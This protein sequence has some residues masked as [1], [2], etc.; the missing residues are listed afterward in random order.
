[1]MNTNCLSGI[2]CPYCGFED[3]FKIEVVALARVTDEGVMSTSSEGS[4]NEWFPDSPIVCGRCRRHGVV[5]EFDGKPTKVHLVQEY[6]LDG[7][8]PALPLCDWQSAV[9]AGN[10]RDSYWEWVMAELSRRG[11]HPISCHEGEEDLVSFYQRE[12]QKLRSANPGSGI[13]YPTLCEMKEVIRKDLDEV[14]YSFESF[15]AFYDWWDVA[16]AYDQM[17]E[18][19]DSRD[20]KPLLFVAYKALVVEGAL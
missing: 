1:M 14:D 20:Y 2:Q 7:E 11:W 5:E 8:H 13:V 6:G 16:T 18:G 17:D 3:E 15:D 19:E 12:L 4:E 10:S 9:S